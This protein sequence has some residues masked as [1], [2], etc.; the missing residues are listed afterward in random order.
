MDVEEAW[1]EGR[2]R[3]GPKPF[4]VVQRKRK[5]SRALSLVASGDTPL[6]AA[7][8]AHAVLSRQGGLYGY[9]LMLVELRPHTEPGSGLKKRLLEN[10]RHV[11]LLMSL[12]VAP[13][14]TR[15]ASFGFPRTRRRIEMA[16]M[17]YHTVVWDSPERDACL[18]EIKKESR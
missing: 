18:L 14:G 13:Q 7:Q 8:R 9:G 11:R 16:L 10:A 5:G 6:E 15:A 12:V 4:A 2:K 17:P 1:A 3:K